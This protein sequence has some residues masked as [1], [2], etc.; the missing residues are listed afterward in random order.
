MG[1]WLKQEPRLVF[2]DLEPVSFIIAMNLLNRRQT[3]PVL[4][5]V[6]SLPWESAGFS[7][8]PT[9]CVC[10]TDQASSPLTHLLKW[11]RILTWME[12]LELS[13]LVST[14]SRESE[15]LHSGWEPVRASCKA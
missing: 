5:N 14:F 15:Y 6:G 4:G 11:V 3:L 7:L 13:L 8:V 1:T 2:V 12:E 10:L 9:A